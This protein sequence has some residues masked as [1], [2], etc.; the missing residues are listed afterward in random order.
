MLALPPHISRIGLYTGQ[1]YLI[2]ALYFT[3]SKKTNLAIISSSIYATTM[4][5]WHNIKSSGVAKTVD[6]AVVTASILFVTFRESYNFLNHGRKIW[7]SVILV[8]IISYITNTVVTTVPV[9]QMTSE[10]FTPEKIQLLTTVSHTF[11]LHIMPS[12]TAM[13][14]A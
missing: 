1:M 7:N 11:W 8:S 12:L 14:C 3:H 9:L 5:H 13:W 4:I 6:L 2:S 10:F